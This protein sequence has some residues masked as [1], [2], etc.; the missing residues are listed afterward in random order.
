MKL[1]LTYAQFQKLIG[2]NN[3]INC[4]I[5]VI[6]QVIYD[7]RLIFG[8]E[9]MVFFALHSGKRSGNEFLEDAYNKGVRNFVV[10]AV[11]EQ[12]KA[13]ANYFLV[14]NVLAALQD[15]AIYFRK[16]YKGEVVGITGTLGKTTFKEWA[17]ATLLPSKTVYRSPKSYNSQLGVALSI[18]SG[19]QSADIWLIEAGISEPG[20][21]IR[22][23]EI[24]QPTV[25]VF[26]HFG[27]GHGANFIAETEYFSEKM[28]LFSNVKVL[29]TPNEPIFQ[30]C[31]KS[32]VL[33]P[34][35]ADENNIID[36][37][38]TEKS[39]KQT[40]LLVSR[41]ARYFQID[42]AVIRNEIGKLEHLSLRLETFE[43]VLGSTIINDTYTL[44]EEAFLEAL[45]YQKEVAQKRPKILFL[46]TTTQFDHFKALAIQEGVDIVYSTASIDLSIIVKEIENAVV[47]I[48]GN[49]SA[50]AES[51]T[52]QLKLKKHKTQLT[53][54]L[55]EVKHNITEMTKHLPKF[56][57]VLAMVK[58]GGYGA[59]AEQ[60]S[61]FLQRNGVAY[62]GVAYADEGVELRKAGITKPILIM[63]AEEEAFEDIIA[64]NL[65]PA[66]YDLAQ[67]NVFVST[68]INLGVTQFPI[69]LKLE[70]GMNRLGF[71]TGDLIP[72]LA[73]INAQ[74]EI[75]VVGV[76]SHLADSDNLLSRDFT[77]QQIIAFNELCIK[78]EAQL[79]NKFIKH[80][81]NSEG[82]ANYA[83]ASFDMVRLGIG[84]YG[85]V[86][87]PRLANHLHPVVSWNS[88][89]SQVK[90]VRTG[91]SVGYSASFC[92]K[93]AMEIAV[94]PVGYADGFK[95]SLGNGKGTVYI[96]KHPCTTIG[97]IC[98]DMIMV[99]V[100]GLDVKRG[101][102]VEI[103]GEQ[104]SLLA[105]AKLIDSIP[106]EVLTSI[107]K[108]VH[109]V[110]IEA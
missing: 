40:A 50:K 21:M 72:L 35:S 8:Q 85:C 19:N 69:Q 33:H 91:E 4:A 1:A 95:R 43:G 65:E 98:M 59:G 54:N 105:F 24:I 62:F 47:L 110:Y 2:S 89:V 26:T 103:I 108:R 61:L 42:S 30:K 58:A 88:T 25:G 106:Y 28:Q 104:Q 107:S 67:L 32:E 48:K 45:A 77:E 51:L 97:R 6:D 52:Q 15:L 84:M 109:R 3:P 101:D 27:K 60:L 64:W 74:P 10:S 79:P 17:S 93:E 13:D 102:S 18:L 16:S 9:N 34:T 70:T 44:D 86:N 81:L 55:S 12:P 57:N 76:Y 83:Y 63:N 56:T 22:L 71:S 20:E 75:R 78:I 46:N 11:P 49:R 38:F 73:M 66:I 23:Y 90:N 92:A 100:T 31:E 96:N 80:L 14:E 87:D 7:T 36:L 82:V 39:S 5:G 29:I 68:C 37:P 41:L 94:I 99:N 53:I